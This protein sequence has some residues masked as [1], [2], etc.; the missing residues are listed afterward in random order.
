MIRDY[1]NRVIGKTQS[2]LVQ[3]QAYKSKNLVLSNNWDGSV[4]QFYHF[5]FG[6]L[7][8]LSLWL[9]KNSTDHILVRD[10]GPMNIWLE[11]IDGNPRIEPIPAGSALHIVIGD[12]LSHTVL[13]GFDD[14]DKF[15]RKRLIQGA[16][17]IQQRL[18]LDPYV[19]PSEARVLVVDRAS[20]EDF[21]HQHGSETEMSGKERRHVPNLKDL[22][23]VYSGSLS[24]TVLDLARLSPREQIQQA[25]AS[26]VLIGQHGAGLAHMLWM[27]PGS[28]VV[29]IA[30]P[31]PIQVQNIFSRLAETLGHTYTRISQQDVHAE[32]DLSLVIQAIDSNK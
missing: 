17:S 18:A 15:N 8:P 12:R 6:Y 7:M 27:P 11:A 5:L 24:V 13:R 21:Y 19:L 16:R 10:C 31:L 20:S 2:K 29:E 1:A 14:P 30:P 26:T 22:P 4:Q 3:R 25:Q 32:I 23:H 28:H 9:D